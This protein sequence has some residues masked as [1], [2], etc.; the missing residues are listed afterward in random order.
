M[1]GSCCVVQGHSNRRNEAA[2]TDRTRDLWVRFIRIKRNNFFPQS[3]A[4][5]VIHSVH[6]EENCFSD[7]T[8]STT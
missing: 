3:H 6:L 5:F 2:G 4:K 1:V 7:P 8:V